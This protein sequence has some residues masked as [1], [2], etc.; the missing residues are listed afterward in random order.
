VWFA[1]KGNS[2]FGLVVCCLSWAELVLPSL[3]ERLVLGLRLGL[4]L[5]LLLCLGV[6]FSVVFT[7]AVVLALS[8]PMSCLGL[9]LCLVATVQPACSLKAV[10]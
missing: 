1:E 6:V 7:F 9:C 2:G 3:C 10:L 4:G 5:C 8:W